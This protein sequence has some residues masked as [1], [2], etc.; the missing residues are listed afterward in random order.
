MQT[1]STTDRRLKAFLS[2]SPSES[3]EV[4][5]LYQRLTRDGVD[6]W[7][8]TEKVLARHEWQREIEEAVRAADVILICFSEQ[9]Q[10]EFRQEEVRIALEEAEKHSRRETFIIPVR[11]GESSPP[12]FL[13]HY[14]MVDLFQ[15]DGY[16]SLLHTLR[17]RAKQL[18]LRPEAIT[19]EKTVWFYILDNLRQ[20]WEL[21]GISRASGTFPR[22]S[23]DLNDFQRSFLLEIE[24]ITQYARAAINSETTYNRRQQLE[25]ALQRTRE[26][27][28]YVITASTWQAP[29]DITITLKRW[30]RIFEKEIAGTQKWEPIPNVYVAGMPLEENSVV[31]KGRK[32][33]IRILEREFA[34]PAAQ[35]PAILL[36]GARR[37]GKTSVLRQFPDTLGPQVIPV[38]V[39][40]QGL[41]LTNNIAT[42]F[43]QWSDSIRKSALAL[44][45]IK[46]EEISRPAL[47]AD[48][49]IVFAEW[50]KTAE[51]TI[52]NRWLL[53]SLD[54]YEYIETLTESGRAD[55][56][57][58]QLLRS[59]LQNYPRLTLLFSGTHTFDELSPV[60][61]H[62]L[63]NVQTIK[64]GDLEKKD[65][66]ELIEKPIKSFPLNYE[67]EAVD[68]ILSVV[69]GQPYL[70]QVTCRELVNLM[71]DKS[72][73]Q[74]RVA[75]VDQALDAALVSGA[76]YFK[77]VWM[78]PESSSSRRKMMASIARQKGKPVSERNLLRAGTSQDI[79]HLVDH[80]VIEKMDGGYCFKV[81]LVRRGIEKQI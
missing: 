4:R 81:E 68:R 20:A 14:P 27:N 60:W 74:A 45:R 67:A 34:T 5:S 28:S 23:N 12:D 66:R 48:P 79:K 8:D 51:E 47:E 29:F 49:Y 18:G 56:R 39:D 69:G 65:A 10:L 76:A 3:N 38:R 33:I 75:D 62:H 43:E 72:Q 1:M 13:S 58:F 7:L 63:I 50:M 37:T 55:V 80:D 57:I 15:V 19:Q 53:L 77:E 54:E 46:V 24:T 52:G 17:S 32:D 73:L 42:F 40:L 59:L 31:F 78:N 9:F 64:I 71:N 35:R 6:A 26:L 22:L 16:E 21:E 11:L 25:H 70:L 44:R 2:Y 41:A 36:F 61:S 30:I